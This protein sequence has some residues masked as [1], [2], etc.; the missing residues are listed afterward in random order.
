MEIYL[1]KK[2]ESIPVYQTLVKL[3]ESLDSSSLQQLS[4][5]DIESTRHLYDPVLDFIEFYIKTAVDNTIDEE[6]KIYIVNA[7]YAA[8]GA[9]KIFEMIRE[10]LKIELSYEYKFPIIKLVN[11][12]SIVINNVSKYVEKFT[13]MI[14]YLLYYTKITIHIK[15]LIL[16]LQG[17]LITYRSVKS[18]GFNTYN[19]SPVY[20][21]LEGND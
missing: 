7:L 5:D 8:K 15:H 21:D 9:P 14:Y 4:I 18:I 1:N 10:L 2:L 20:S 6:R 17:N 13:N 19:L 11:F 12:E 3:L 16:S